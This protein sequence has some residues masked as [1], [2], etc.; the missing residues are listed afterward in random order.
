MTRIICVSASVVLT[1]THVEGC[2]LCKTEVKMN[3]DTSIPETEASHPDPPSLQFVAFQVAPSADGS[4][5]VSLASTFLDEENLEFLSE[6]IETVAA[7]NI[8]EAVSVI[9][10]GLMDAL[11]AHV[12]KEKH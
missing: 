9:R 2:R 6:D 3:L 11:H 7:A 12:Q 1:G 10:R 4:L 5:R 8:E